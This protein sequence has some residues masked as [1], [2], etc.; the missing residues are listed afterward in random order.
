M[1]TKEFHILWEAH[2]ELRALLLMVSSS[3]AD[4]VFLTSNEVMKML[5]IS[6]STLYRLRINKV[7][8]PVFIHKRYYYPKRLITQEILERALKLDDHTK[9]FDKRK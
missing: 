9:R 5:N 2:I 7:I 8:T 4:E 3:T 1:R 6:R